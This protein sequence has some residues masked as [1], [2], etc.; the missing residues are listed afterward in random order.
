MAIVGAVSAF[1]DTEITFFF[2]IDNPDAIEKFQINFQDI[3]PQ[4]GVTGYT[5]TIADNNSLGVYTKID[6]KE[7]YIFDGVTQSDGATVPWILSNRT[8]SMYVVATDN[9][10]TW[11]V[12]TSDLNA[13]RTG[14]LTM[15]IDNI[16][17]L[18]VHE[19]VSDVD[20]AIANGANTIRF[21]PGEKNTI[22]VIPN[23]S[24]DPLYRVEVNGEKVPVGEFGRYTF[25][26]KDGDVVD[27]MANFPDTNFPVHFTYEPGAEKIITSVSVNNETV[28][29]FDGKELSVKAGHEVFMRLDDTNFQ[30]SEVTINGVAQS[31]IYSSLYFTPLEETTVYIG[32]HPYGNITAYITID[33]P[34]NAIVYQGYAYENKVIDL[35]AGRNEIALPER[36][37]KICVWHSGTGRVASITDGTETYEPGQYNLIQLADGTELNITTAPIVRDDRVVVWL[38]SRDVFSSLTFN[39]GTYDFRTSLGDKLTAGYNH[40][41]I[42]PEVD[43]PVSLSWWT[44]TGQYNT[45]Y[46]NDE[47]ASPAYPGGVMYDLPRLEDGSVVKVFVATE[48]QRHETTFTL[49][50]GVEADVTTDFITPVADLSA[51]LNLLAGT[52]VKIAPR[53]GA[54]ITVARDNETLTPDEEGNYSFIADRPS[55]VAIEKDGSVGIDAVTGT[56]TLGNVYSLQGILIKKNA[57]AADL[58]RLPAG[59]YIIN[60]KKTILK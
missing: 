54:Q 1:A 56:T 47:Q 13:I 32:A 51:P 40:I 29:D 50:D 55:T 25:T 34:A 10:K 57:T 23:S 53:N 49:A 26:P 38:D 8:L 24:Y 30:I 11:T 44:T 28:N 33:D 18:R 16:S 59:I 45:V 39:L 43:N 31:N 5:I 41:L 3:T 37:A 22:T 9:Q 17:K 4:K 48:P 20:Y 14:T 60:G 58:D 7:G 19:D 21:I 12:R 46:V 35:K 27:V 2:D 6:L 42:D 15:N 52:M 36:S